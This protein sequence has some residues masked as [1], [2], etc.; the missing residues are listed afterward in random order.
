VLTSYLHTGFVGVCTICIC[1]Q[2]GVSTI[3]PRAKFDIYQV[4]PCKA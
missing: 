1:T 2:F 3:Y 4:F